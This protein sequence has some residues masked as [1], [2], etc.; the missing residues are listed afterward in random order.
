MRVLFSPRSPV[1]IDDWREYLISI[2][3]SLSED[4]VPTVLLTPLKSMYQKYCLHTCEHIAT[5]SN[6]DHTIHSIL[7]INYK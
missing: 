2:L 7:E 3:V 5:L 1:R 6:V 4:R